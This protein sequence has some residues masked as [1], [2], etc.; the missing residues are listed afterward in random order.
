MNITEEIADVNDQI[1]RA[2]KAERK[3]K[4]VLIMRELDK[5][6]K[7]FDGKMAKWELEYRWLSS[8][9][10]SDPECV[11][12]QGNEFTYYQSKEWDPEKRLFEQFD[13]F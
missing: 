12:V 11:C 9:P 1:P 13:L 10:E 3:D 2:C 5:P 6:F 4:N 8:T 7:R